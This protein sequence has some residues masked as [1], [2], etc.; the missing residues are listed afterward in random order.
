MSENKKNMQ[1]E[2]EEEKLN[3]TVAQAESENTEET[4]TVEA[5]E[6]VEENE[7]DKLKNEL[8]ESKDKFIRLYSEFE[9]FRR[10][11]AKEKIEVIQ[12]A[13]E[14]LIK[15]LLPV[16]D[17]FERAQKSIETT[18]DINAIKEGILLIFNKLQKTLQSK[19]L[20]AIEAKDQ[21]FDVEL[22]ECITQFAAGDD[23]KGLVIDEVEKGYYLN[24][25]VIRYSKVVV[26]N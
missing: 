9:N 13:S 5:E 2:N 22:H 16:M 26:G 1:Q 12:N 7:T 4:P 19:G 15:E 17:D 3:E 20:K 6:V 25:K 8:A 10:R 18:E 23:K 11:T 24:E 14:G 21:P